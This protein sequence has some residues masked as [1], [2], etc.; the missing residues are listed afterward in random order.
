MFASQGQLDWHEHLESLMTRASGP[1]DTEGKVRG[2]R[3][4]GLG[5][6]ATLEGGSAKKQ[7]QP[8]ASPLPQD[9]PPGVG[10]RRQRLSSRSLDGAVSSLQPGGTAR[11]GAPKKRT[12]KVEDDHC[13]FEMDEDLASNSLGGGG[14][15]GGEIGAQL[16]SGGCKRVARPSHPAPPHHTPCAGFSPPP[17]RAATPPGARR[18]T[19]AEAAARAGLPARIV[20]EVPG[21]STQLRG[22]SLPTEAR[23]CPRGPRRQ[24]LL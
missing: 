15:S 19:A 20:F 13:V 7:Q 18:F 1:W 10:R 23:V 12:F 9:P 2:G 5:L 4:F 6:H 14:A 3:P 17:A 16:G 11:T 8:F 24:G 21:P 22:K